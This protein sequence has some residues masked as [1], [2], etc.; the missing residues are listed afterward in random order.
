MFKAELKSEVLKSLVYVVSTLVDE[1]KLC[2][3]PDSVTIQAIDPAHIAMV[4]INVN[5]DAFQS[6]EADE[7][8]IGLDL[9]KVKSILK[10]AG[11]SDIIKMEH[12]PD[13]GRLTITIGNIV[14]RMSL[15]ETNG[16]VNPKVPDLDIPASIQIPVEELQKGIRAS[17]SISDH[18]KL[19]LSPESFMLSCEGDLDFAR[20]ELPAS[21]TVVIDTDATVSS[22]Y[23][24]DFFSN[25]IKVIP[26][27]TVVEL[28][29]KK[30]H[31]IM[32]IFSLAKDSV[33]V[34]YLLAPRCDNE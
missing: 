24:L 10:L 22:D 29:F 19:T 8:E 21:E 17:E 16:I 23:P 6:Y 14:R 15:V 34:K 31:P 3:H 5:M 28:R 25:I 2:A 27:G 26:A 9:D 7:S 4:D 18:L 11:P 30:D 33:R 20:L 12:D 32:V 13:Q 1:V